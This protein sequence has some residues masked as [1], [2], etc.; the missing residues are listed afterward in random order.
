MNIQWTNITGIGASAWHHDDKPLV[1]PSMVHHQEKI[2]DLVL[3]HHNVKLHPEHQHHI[4]HHHPH[5]IPHPTAHH[6]P[7]HTPK[8]ITHHIPH[9]AAHH[10]HRHV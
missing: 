7:Y 3:H 2:P 1:I 6:L 5:H 9:N 10:G 8:H 4:A